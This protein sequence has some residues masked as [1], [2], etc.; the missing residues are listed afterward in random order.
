MEGWELAKRHS[1]MEGSRELRTNAQTEP[2]SRLRSWKILRGWHGFPIWRWMT[3]RHMF[4][5]GSGKAARG[6]GGRHSTTPWILAISIHLILPACRE[7]GNPSRQSPSDALVSFPKKRT[8][9]KE[10]NKEHGTGQNE[11]RA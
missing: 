4:A 1:A 2:T 5:A 6:W 3:S 11:Y 8:T 7:R 10:R 9:K